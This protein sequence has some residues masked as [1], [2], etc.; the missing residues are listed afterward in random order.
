MSG[1]SF[2]Q[3]KPQ[4]Y[5]NPVNISLYAKTSSPTT[6]RGRGNPPISWPFASDAVELRGIRSRI[7]LVR[8]YFIMYSREVRGNRPLLGRMAS[9]E[10]PESIETM[11]FVGG[12]SSPEAQ[13]SGSGDLYNWRAPSFRM[14]VLWSRGCHNW[15]RKIK[16]SSDLTPP[17]MN[18]PQTRAF[19]AR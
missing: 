15:C 18:Y 2:S 4:L 16:S 7:H 5:G 9:P 6:E 19:V 8:S 17:L 14:R 1:D 10:D 13:H 3:V 11:C 12:S